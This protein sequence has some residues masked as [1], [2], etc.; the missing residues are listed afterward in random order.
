MLTKT[1]NMFFTVTPP[2]GRALHSDILKEMLIKNGANALSFDTDLKG[3]LESAKEYAGKD[4]L[5]VICGSLYLASDMRKI[6][7]P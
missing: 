5:V 2:G 3:A 7:N 4:G 1:G 6:I